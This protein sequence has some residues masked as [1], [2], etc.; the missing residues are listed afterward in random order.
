M[1]GEKP[2]P[3]ILL[4]F[5]MEEGGAFNKVIGNIHDKEG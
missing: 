1:D 5:D 2:N 3:D 4:W